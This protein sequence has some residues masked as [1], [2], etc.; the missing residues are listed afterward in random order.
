MVPKKGIILYK[1]KK[2][3]REAKK[4]SSG[5]MREKEKGRQIKTLFVGYETKPT[6]LS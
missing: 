6:G 3:F 4:S 5:K 1:T 2:G